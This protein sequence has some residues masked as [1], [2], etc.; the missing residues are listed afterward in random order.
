VTD[1]F[2]WKRKPSTEHPKLHIKRKHMIS[3]S[4]VPEFKFTGIV[5]SFT[6]IARKERLKILIQ[7][8]KLIQT[9]QKLSLK[10]EKQ[11]NLFHFSFLSTPVGLALWSR[12]ALRLCVLKIEC[13]H[14]AASFLR[15]KPLCEESKHFLRYLFSNSCPCLF[16]SLMHINLNRHKA[17]F[18]SIFF[19]CIQLKYTGRNNTRTVGREQ[20]IFNKWGIQG[21]ASHQRK[22]YECPV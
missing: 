14:M 7:Y 8:E 1:N 22:E 5:D 21:W 17:C 2:P 16:L 9:W 12:L 11:L 19:L 18:F 3:R 20:Q 10:R 13:G 15:T 6:E 4:A